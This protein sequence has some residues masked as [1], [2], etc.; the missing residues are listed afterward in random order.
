MPPAAAR[1]RRSLSREL[2]D[3]RL[4]E[5]SKRRRSCL[6]VVSTTGRCTA[7][8]KCF[9]A[10]QRVPVAANF[11]GHERKRTSI[12]NSQRQESLSTHGGCKSSSVGWRCPQNTEARESYSS[13]K[14]RTALAYISQCS[15]PLSC[16]CAL[17]E[18]ISQFLMAAPRVLGP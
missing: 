1:R 3:S 7:E 18:L 6:T 14:P 8:H 9:A 10:V 2:K 11:L 5:D 13:K 17:C 16:L 4:Y 12:H 15:G